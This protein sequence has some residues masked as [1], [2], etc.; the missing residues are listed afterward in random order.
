MAAVYIDYRTISWGAP[1]EDDQTDVWQ[2]EDGSKDPGEILLANFGTVGTPINNFPAPATTGS[3]SSP[4][5]TPPTA[6]ARS[7]TT[8]RPHSS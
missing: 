7:R 5:G 4:S 8:P 1:N 6:S 2:I 3:Y